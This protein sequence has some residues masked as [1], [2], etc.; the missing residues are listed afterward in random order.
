MRGKNP[1]LRSGGKTPT[2]ARSNATLTWGLDSA[3]RRM[4][5]TDADTRLRI[6]VWGAA[7]P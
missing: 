3:M 7:L 6:I 5:L 2:T 1:A 4:R